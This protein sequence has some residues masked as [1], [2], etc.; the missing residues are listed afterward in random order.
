[1]S[2]LV[3]DGSSGEGG[4]QLSRYAVALAA[5]TG[6][7]L[8]LKNIR[9]RRAKPGLMA[10]HLTALRA[11]AAIGGGV[12]EGDELG[13]KE[14]CY[15]PGRS[16]GGEYR[17]DVGTAGS[18]TLVLQALLP[19]ALHA[20][21]AVHLSVSGGTDVRKAP[22]VDYFVMVFLPWLARM[23]VRVQ[24]ESIHHGYYPKGGGR[25]NLRVEPCQSLRPLAAEAPGAV[26]Q[27]TGLSHVAHLPQHIPE[28][29][30]SSARSVLAGLGPVRIE[31]K[32]LGDGEA[33]GTGGAMVLV[34]E[35]EHSLLGAATVAE[36][37]VPAERLGEEAGHALRAELEAGAALDIHACDQLL[38]YAAM[39]AGESRMMVRKVSQHA[40]TVMWLIEQFLPAR[41]TVTPCE[42]GSRIDIHPG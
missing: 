5:I 19:V 8:H 42:G 14:V 15:Q 11:A 22:P 30:A 32:V 16:R 13:A 18:I 10:Q 2:Q 3:I 31:E 6:R 7:S 35:T 21:T 12:L 17:F 33:F 28:R 25:V 29:M 24:I 4:G 20:D 27:I 26:Q 41:F 38:L 9:A 40:E 39:A 23:G 34:A 36:R 37:G 1:M